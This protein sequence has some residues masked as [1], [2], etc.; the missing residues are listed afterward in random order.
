[1]SSPRA[2]SMSSLHHGRALVNARRAASR[3]RLWTAAVVV[4]AG[5]VVGLSAVRGERAAAGASDGTTSND[6]MS[7]H[8]MSSGLS[9]PVGVTASMHV[10]AGLPLEGGRLTCT[11]CHDDQAASGHASRTPR[12]E[13]FLRLDGEAA[14]LCS[15]CHVAG[16][17]ASHHGT[18]SIKAHLQAE[19]PLARG[20]GSKVDEES[21]QC[22]SC[23]DGSAASDAGGKAAGHSFGA[24]SDHAIGVRYQSKGIGTPEE[25]RLTPLHQLD[26][27]VRLFDSTVGCGSCHSVYSGGRDLLVMS[28][29]GSKLCLACHVE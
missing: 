11:T 14:T 24:A 9:H 17:L 3:V 10:P 1:M 16:T 25:I 18:S 15:Q 23:H 2:A 22:L 20:M 27:R 12:G 4:L 7:C 5:G 13:S 29:S 26:R 21:R 8:Q 6:C 19:P 28:N